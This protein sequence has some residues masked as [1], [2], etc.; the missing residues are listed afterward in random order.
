MPV[1]RYTGLTY[2]M[3]L[4]E[5]DRTILV[6]NLYTALAAR[7]FTVP[8][9]APTQDLPTCLPT[10]IRDSRMSDADE[11]DRRQLGV[12]SGHRAASTTAPESPFMATTQNLP[13]CLPAHIRESRMSLIRSRKRIVK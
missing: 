7:T 1:G 11:T 5:L 6:L 4:G 3:I 9:V 2:I 13:T 10:H 12:E 8:L